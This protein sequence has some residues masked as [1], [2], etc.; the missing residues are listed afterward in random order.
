MQK[1]VFIEILNPDYYADFAHLN[2]AWL[3]G[4]GLVEPLDYTELRDPHTT[5]VA[6]GGIIFGAFQSGNLVGTSVVVP[7]GDDAFEIA[8]LA[9]DP[10]AQR[11]G[12]G[13]LLAQKCIDYATAQGAAKVVLISNTKLTPALSLYKAIGFEDWPIPLEIQKY[14]TADVYME[15]N[16]SKKAVQQ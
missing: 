16:L 6:K 5:Y 14:A 15:L 11:Q 2:L 10:S 3:E 9:V 7:Y 13:R 4:S 12:I 1:L 8:K